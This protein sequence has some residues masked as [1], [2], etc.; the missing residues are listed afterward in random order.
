MNDPST[1]DHQC[2]RLRV[3]EMMGEQGLANNGERMKPEGH[4]GAS[5]TVVPREAFSSSSP[6]A[7]RILLDAAL[8]QRLQ[9]EGRLPG[10]YIGVR[11]IR[12]SS[13]HVAQRLGGRVVVPVHSSVG[14]DEV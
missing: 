5:P 10:S 14:A 7:A 2:R 8:V 4:G 6:H 11:K 3:W 9:T 1:N 13:R 12:P